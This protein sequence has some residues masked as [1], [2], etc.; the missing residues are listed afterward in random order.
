MRSN[1]SQLNGK[2]VNGFL[3]AF[4]GQRGLAVLIDQAAAH[5]MMAIRFA[6]GCCENLKRL[7]RLE[8]AVTLAQNVSQSCCTY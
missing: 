5:H 8:G 4:Q 7:K 6:D 3:F 2:K 1:K